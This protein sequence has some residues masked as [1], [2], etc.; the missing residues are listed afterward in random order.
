MRRRLVIP[1]IASIAALAGEN[2]WASAVLA[3][4]PRLS[5]NVNPTRTTM[6]VE[7]QN[8]LDR[9]IC[10][11]PS[12]SRPERFAVLE[13][14]RPLP[15]PGN[16]RRRNPPEC[17]LLQPRGVLTAQYNVSTLYPK[18]PQDKPIEF[19]YALPWNNG[20]LPLGAASTFSQCLKV[21]APAGRQ[22]KAPPARG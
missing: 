22:A 2:A 12:Y 4:G 21:A 15:G 6:N 13:D 7:I 20:S 8:P 17:V 14:G 10:V 9:T 5:I 11:R 19:C 3:T 1:L 16:S 18:L